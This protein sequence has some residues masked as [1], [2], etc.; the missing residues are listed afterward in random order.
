MK[1]LPIVL[2]LLV[3]GC[4]T[5]PTL[6]AKVDGEVVTV[7]TDPGMCMGNCTWFDVAVSSDGKGRLRI[8]HN[9]VTMKFRAFRVPA[10]TTERF[11]SALARERRPD[12]R[13]LDDRDRCANFAFDMGGYHVVWKGHR[14]TSRLDVN[15]GCIDPE[16]EEARKTISEALAL[17]PLGKL[18]A[19]S[20]GVMATTIV[21]GKR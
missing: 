2:P 12:D 15:D 11:Q 17:L 9:D 3:G 10:E 13:S 19:P 7:E 8:Y 20:G 21:S 18:P 14:T 5:V 4:L 1:R 6:P 16:A